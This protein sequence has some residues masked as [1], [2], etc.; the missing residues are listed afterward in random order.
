MRGC[1]IATAIFLVLAAAAALTAT[2][3]VNWYDVTIG[4]SKTHVGLLKTC[5]EDTCENN[6]FAD[7]EQCDRTGDGMQTRIH[8]V[9]GLILGGAGVAVIG[10]G[11]AVFAFVKPA[12]ALP[13]IAL[14]LCMVSAAASGSSAALFVYSIENWYFCDKTMCE[15]LNV[16]GCKNELAWSFFIACGAVALALIGFICQLVSVLTAKPA[17]EGE[18]RPAIGGNEPYR[19][20]TQQANGPPAGGDWVHDAASGLWWSDA[21]QL[22]LDTVTYQ[23]YDPHSGNWYDPE[24]QQWY[25]KD[26]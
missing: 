14:L 25:S 19:Q 4:D 8:A 10:A 24:S 2:F 3:T 20:T 18:A 15:F 21:E 17:I 7:I 12:S 23:Y 11:V 1:S 6:D 13:P 22:Y 26:V 9:M 5:I 16:D